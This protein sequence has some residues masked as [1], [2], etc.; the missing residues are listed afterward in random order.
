[1]QRNFPEH[2]KQ[3]FEI[4]DILYWK[5]QKKIVKSAKSEE[6]LIMINVHVAKSFIGK[7]EKRNF[8]I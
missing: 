2:F 4:Q 1:M 3:I 8:E 6:K 5:V 7:T